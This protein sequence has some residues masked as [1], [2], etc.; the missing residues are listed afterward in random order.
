LPIPGARTA[1]GC[2][3]PQGD[4]Q[5]AARQVPGPQPHEVRA[6]PSGDRRGVCGAPPRQVPNARQVS[7]RSPSGRRAMDSQ[8]SHRRS[9]PVAPPAT[10]SEGRRQAKRSCRERHRAGPGRTARRAPA[11][12]PGRCPRSRSTCRSWP[13]GGQDPHRDR[14]VVTRAVLRRSARREVDC[15]PPCRH[16]EAAV[17]Q[18]APH[19]FAGLLHWLPP[20]HD[21][22][23]RSPEATSPR[24]APAG[25]RHP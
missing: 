1:P 9:S 15:D 24:P 16:L 21:R 22:E 12:R 4:L 2:G 20:D 18:R 17:A 10:I 23:C 11:P 5:G 25:P 14:Q 6:T 19:P 7:D 8:P 13:R 3:G